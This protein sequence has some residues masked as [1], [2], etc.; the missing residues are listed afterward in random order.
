[1]AASAEEGVIRA[2]GSAP[3]SSFAHL[4]CITKLS[5][6]EITM[7][8][9]ALDGF[10]TNGNESNLLFFIGASVLGAYFVAL[11][12]MVFLYLV[13]RPRQEKKD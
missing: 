11:A 10:Y 7:P 1:V 4:L 13:L 8:L 5:I 3:A 12:A 6:R 9:F 2:A